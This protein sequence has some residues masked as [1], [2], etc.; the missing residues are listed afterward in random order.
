MSLL[1]L[2]AALAALAAGLAAY[3][4]YVSA[5]AE[6]ALPMRGRI[7]EV[8]GGT[9]HWIEA[10]EGPPVVLIHG[11]SGNLHNFAGLA[12]H[13]SRDF[14]VISLDR[15]GNGYAR[16]DNDAL[17][18]LPEQATM[19][20]EFL[21]EEGIERPVVVGHSLGG[22]VALQL[23][24]DF[25]EQVGAIALLCPLT[26]YEPEV[27]PAFRGMEVDSPFL[28]RAIASTLAVPVSKIKAHGMLEQIFFPD[29]VP[30][31]FA[32]RFGGIL[33]FR[34][35]SFVAAS[36]DLV[37]ATATIARLA[38]R[39]RTLGVA[40]GVQFGASDAILAPSRHGQTLC[41]AAPQLIYEELPNR[42]HMTPVVDPAA[43]A[44]FV[45]RVAAKA[46][47]SER[48]IASL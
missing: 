42:G 24:L 38:A 28:R 30:A 2:V 27:P 32:I 45:R 4:R 39:F 20:A 1:V 9:I 13:L 40:G 3:S 16:R 6:R 7:A 10:G 31:D 12:D 23:A 34:P 25:P 18:A 43:C 36:A 44:D 14:R 5:K 47:P 26:H 37:M 22:A 35:Q 48:I 8:K 15:P 11:L 46:T 19:I 33:A 29:P 17:A 41:N 21:R